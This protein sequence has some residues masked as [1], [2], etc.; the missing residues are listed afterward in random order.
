MLNLKPGDLLEVIKFPVIVWRD[1][2]REL[3]LHRFGELGRG[4]VVIFF[5]FCQG[6]HAFA[7]SKF[8]MCNVMCDSKSVKVVIHETG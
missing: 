6:N 5:E 2:V 3:S 8:G 7:L 1:N 4:D